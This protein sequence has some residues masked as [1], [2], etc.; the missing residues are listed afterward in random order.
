MSCGKDRCA[1]NRAACTSSA[2]PS[3]LRPSSNSKVSEVLP[4][5][6]V[7]L[8]KASPGMVWNCFSKGKATDVAMVSGL[9]PGK[10]AN[11]L[12]TGVS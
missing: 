4:K 7:E 12:M 8:I 11:T 9:A 6:L 1:R 10:A 3:M 2:A 5:V